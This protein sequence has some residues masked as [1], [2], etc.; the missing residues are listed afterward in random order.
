MNFDLWA[1]TS[2]LC[3]C[4][5]IF[6]WHDG[7]RWSQALDQWLHPWRT[8]FFF[9]VNLNHLYIWFISEFLLLCCGYLTD[10]HVYQIRKVPPWENLNQRWTKMKGYG[11]K[12]SMQANRLLIYNAWSHWSVDPHG[13]CFRLVGKLWVWLLWCRQRLPDFINTCR[14]LT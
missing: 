1:S 4:F 6:P 12:G 11:N 2:Q 7:L 5:R 8:N 10:P 14:Q 3:L 9:Y 13:T